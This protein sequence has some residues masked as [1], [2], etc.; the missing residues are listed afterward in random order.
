MNSIGVSF[1]IFPVFLYFKFLCLIFTET[2][3]EFR[4]ESTSIGKVRWGKSD[5]EGIYG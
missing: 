3:M 4:F 5:W 2:T 1:R